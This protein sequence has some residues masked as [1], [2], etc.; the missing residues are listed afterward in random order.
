MHLG[1]RV[2]VKQNAFEGKHKLSSIWEDTPYIVIEQP[3]PSIP[4]YK[5][6][7]EDKLGRP[8]ILHRNLLLPIGFLPIEEKLHPTST[9]M[10]TKKKSTIPLSTTIDNTSSSEEEW[11]AL[12]SDH[13][14]SISIPPP[15]VHELDEGSTSHESDES[16]EEEI[17]PRR[18]GRV[19]QPPSRYRDSNYITQRQCVLDIVQSLKST[20]V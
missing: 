5:V 20:P 7:R 18:S 16:S 15:P 13:N 11:L 8:R 1:D 6:K 3:N 17:A 4:V 2:L 14:S 12:P 10:S 9:L 19:R